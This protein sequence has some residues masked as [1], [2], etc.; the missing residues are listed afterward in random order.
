[1]EWIPWRDQFLEELLRSEGLGGFPLQCT[2]CQLPASFRCQDCFGLGLLCQTC[3]L[4]THARHPLHRVE[5]RPHLQPCWALLTPSL[6][7]RWNGTYFEE[8]ILGA[9]GLFL[10]L[11]HPAGNTCPLPS[12]Y[13]QLTVFDLTSVHQVIIRYCVCSPE[14]YAYRRRQ[15]LR[16]GWF[17]ATIVHPHTVFTFRLLDF[18][19][20]LQSQNKTNLYD[21]YKTIVHLS[22][23]AGLSLE[24]VSSMNRPV[25]IYPKSF[26]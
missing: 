21:F 19:H 14:D 2:E 13:H 26:A 5:V 12:R 7:Q 8:A 6:W 24:I 10:Q 16:V 25:V 1:M 3:L 4:S 20:Q 18:F 11:G 15:L 23:N 9:L 17:P 22:N